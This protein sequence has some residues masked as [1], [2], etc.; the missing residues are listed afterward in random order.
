ME[1]D[2]NKTYTTVS[3]NRDELTGRRCRIRLA[4]EQR[5]GFINLLGRN[6]RP[7]EVVECDELYAE[8]LVAD[9]LFEMIEP[10]AERKTP[11]RQT[12]PPRPDEA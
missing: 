10:S 12:E 2:V 6:V 3:C 1:T 7:G 4:A 9:G 8:P 5:G 11:P